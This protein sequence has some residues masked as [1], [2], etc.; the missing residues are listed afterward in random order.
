MRNK[1]RNLTAFVS[2][3]YDIYYGIVKLLKLT[4]NY[5]SIPKVLYYFV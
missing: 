3:T 2:H 4:E 5:S 1:L